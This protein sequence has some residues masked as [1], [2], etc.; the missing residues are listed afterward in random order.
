MRAVLDDQH[1]SALLARLVR[2]L[3]RDLHGLQLLLRR[4]DRGSKVRIEVSD[5]ILPVDASLLDT[6]EQQFH[7]GGEVH[8]YDGGESLL[9]H[10]IDRLAEIRH[11]QA[12]AVLGDVVSREERRDRRRIRTRTTDAQLLHRVDE[13]R[14]RVM[15]RRLRKMLLAFH[16]RPRERRADLR[17]V[18]GILL[19]ILLLLGFGVYAAVAFKHTFRCA[20]GK[21]MLSVADREGRHTRYALR[22]AACDEALPDQLVQ[23]ELLVRQ[24]I[25]DGCRCNINIGRTDRFMR[26][27]DLLTRIGSITV[28]TK[29]FL[30]VFCADVIGSHLCGLLAD[31]R[32][33][34]SQ[35][36]DQTDAAVSL[37][38]HA[39]I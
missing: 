23:A 8:R 11:K 15:C 28:G 12:L 22:H 38:L 2:N 34:G 24:L 5:E 3:I 39:F 27:L 1:A 21:C 20:C 6:V 35:V 36:G 16:F 32:R 33:I 18:T 17:H 14:L 10:F 13:A 19:V 7:V 29:E 4:R 30:S 25:L 31:T 9:H 26:V 37:D